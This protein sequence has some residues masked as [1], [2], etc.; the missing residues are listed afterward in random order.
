M[1]TAQ[2]TIMKEAL[3]FLCEISCLAKASKG[4]RGTQPSPVHYLATQLT[5]RIKHVNKTIW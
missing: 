3:L 5:A 2:M 1:D 4:P